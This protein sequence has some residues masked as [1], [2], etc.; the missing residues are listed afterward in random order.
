MEAAKEPSLIAITRPISPAFARGERTHIERQAIDIAAA[1]NEHRAYENALERLGAH[2]I[3]A[4]AAPDL[5]DSVFVEDTAIV[6]DEVAVITRPGAVSRRQ[7]TAGIAQVLSAYRPLLRIEAPATLDGGDVMRV[8][9]V[10]YVGISSRS[11]MDAVAQLQSI[12]KPYEYCVVPVA[13]SGCLH[14]KSAVTAV[15]HKRLLLNRAWIDP[16]VFSDCDLIEVAEDEPFGANALLVRDSVIYPEN[17]PK[18]AEGLAKAGISLVT[19]PCV[20]IA[21]A[22]GAVTCCSLLF[23]R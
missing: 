12:L 11:N 10:L 23:E 7:E 19:T 21:K 22:E 16:N 2:I 14:L 8:D 5:P 3:R 20:E 9:S 13:V 15:G 18:T 17:F 6:L 1:H 4:A